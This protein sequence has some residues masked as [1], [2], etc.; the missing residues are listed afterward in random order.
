MER[1]LVLCRINHHIVSSVLENGKIVELHVERPDETQFHVGD[2]YIGKVKNIVKNIQAAFIEIQ[3]GVECYYQ[4]NNNPTPIFTKKIGKKPLCIGDELLVQIEKEAVKTKAPTVTSNVNLTGKYIVLTHGNTQIG[5]SSKL[6]QEQRAL[7]KEALTD[8]T[9]AS[10]GFIVRTN[11][12]Q[13]SFTELKLEIEK[14]IQAYEQLKLLSQ[15]RTCFSCMKRTPKEYLSSLK[16]IYQDGLQQII[17]EDNELF[18]EVSRFLSEDQAEDMGKLIHYTDSL[19]PLHKLYSVEHVLEEALRERVWMKSG[20]YLVIQPTEALTVIDV[21][22][23]K[24]VL[25]KNDPYAFYKINQ[26]AAAE[27]A[28]QIRLRN[29]SG[30]I[31]IDFINM[32]TLEE[33]KQL[34]AFLKDQLHSDPIR[35]DVIDVTKLQLVELT[36]RKVRKPL[37]EVWKKQRS[38]G[39][40]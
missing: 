6:S 21:N 40:E 22:S 17:I 18:E 36:R 10:Y 31:L 20:A 3:P 16:N 37:H 9:N 26:E 27:A 33:Q 4:M 32:G 34:L 1:K 39:H 7:W 5:V 24:C 29:L 2:I 30:I 23:G 13:L 19:L 28:R 15:S 12:A 11:A 25:K 35:T 38:G 14:Q 8:Y